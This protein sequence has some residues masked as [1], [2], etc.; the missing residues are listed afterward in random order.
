M[1]LRFDHSYCLDKNHTFRSK[2]GKAGFFLKDRMVEHPG[3]MF[4]RFIAFPQ[5]SIAGYQY[6]EFVHIGKGGS[7]ETNPG[8]SLG[9]LGSL[10]KFNS[11]LEKHGLKTT[12]THKN[13]AWKENSVD[14][15]PGW[16]FVEFKSKSNIYTWLTEYELI[17]GR[18]RRLK[19][20]PHPNG[21]Y[22]IVGFD[23]TLSPHDFKFF[24]QVLGS[25]KEQIFTLAGGVKIHFPQEKS[26]K[27]EGVS[28][29]PKI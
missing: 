25:P 17:K 14:L 20:K 26:R 18:P 9:A 16:N 21:A 28:A 23:F 11:K 29:A 15:L 2:L 7:K 24:S 8:F 3:K 1:K 5:T 19:A 13:Y 12:F 27:I 4:C 10:E 6:L 22:K